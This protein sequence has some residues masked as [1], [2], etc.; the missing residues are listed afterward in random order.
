MLADYVLQTNWLVMR[1]SKLD[2]LLL[3]GLMVGFMSLLVLPT[4]LNIVLLPILI[5]TV[6]H[7]IQ[8][9]VK[10]YS[11]PRLKNVHGF[12]TYIADQFGHYLTILILNALVIGSLIVPPNDIEIFVMSVGACVIAITRFYEVTWWANFLQ[13]KMTPY[14]NRWRWFEYAEHLAMFALSLVGL[15]YLAPLCVLPRLLYSRQTPY[16]VTKQQYGLIEML[17][18][19]A[20]AIVLG[21]L[22]GRL[23]PTSLR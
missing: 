8:D 12:Y 1:K 14:F 15:F 22:M 6:L 16:S 9:W 2:G 17:L 21:A 10:V 13:M 7:T 19:A 3:H 11:G 23:F 20:F 18:G 4:H 5:M